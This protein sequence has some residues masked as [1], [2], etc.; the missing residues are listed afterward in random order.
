MSTMFQSHPVAKDRQVQRIEGQVMPTVEATIIDGD[1]DII[2]IFVSNENGATNAKFTI[3]DKQGTAR[4]FVFGAN[5]KVPAEGVVGF[6][7]G[8]GERA[9]GGLTWIQDTADALV[10]RIN[11]R[12]P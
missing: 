6:G 4:I 2:S 10:C 3:K 11:Y 1:A 7:P 5:T 9:T 8:P 12:R